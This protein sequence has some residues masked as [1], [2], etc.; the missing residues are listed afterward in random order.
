VPSPK[1]RPLPI[2]RPYFDRREAEAILEPLR[3]GWLVQGPQVAHFERLVA[4]FCGA[5][6]AVATTSCTTA[7]HLALL[8]AGVRPGTEV[9]VPSFTYVATA[10][11][12][13]YCGAWPVFCDIDPLTFNLDPKEV[14]AKISARTSA[15]V[16]VHLFGLAA[17]M[18]RITSVCRRAGVAVVEDCACSLGGSLRGRHTGTFGLAGCFS[19]HPR[20]C[21]TTGEGGMIV[22]DDPGLAETARQ[23]RDHGAAKSDLARHEQGGTLLPEFNL[24]GYNYRMTDLQG[25]LGVAQMEKLPRILSERRKLAER[26]DDLLGGLSWLGTPFC[27]EGVLH[28]YQSYVCLVRPEEFGGMARANVFRNRLMARL[29]ARGIAC[30]QGTHAVHTLGYYRDK[31]GL[32]EEDLPRSLAAERLSVALPLFVGLRLGDQRRVAAELAS[33]RDEV[34]RRM[35][36]EARTFTPATLGE[37]PAA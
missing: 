34:L 9:L 26:Y 10:N 18:E 23:L 33:G 29:E 7:L 24:L 11:A 28:P 4:A 20:K 22:T 15:A 5:R 35:E 13:E 2:T 14:E 25:A 19:F 6:F 27:P 3:T 8:A 37:R 36:D 16:P 32:S 12:V 30:R 31:Y 21:L 1:P 17:D